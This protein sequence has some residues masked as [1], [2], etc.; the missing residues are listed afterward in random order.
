MNPFQPTLLGGSNAFVAKINPS[1][2]A[3]V[4][5][6]YLGGYEYDIG[7]GI[8]VDGSGDAYVAGFTCST[9]FPTKNA[10]QPIFRGSARNCGY[11]A[12]VTK[13]NPSGSALVYS[14]YLGGTGW[15]EGLGI[16]VDSSGSAYVTGFA[17][18]TDFPT[19]NP[20]QPTRLGAFNAF[21]TEFDP[22][23]SA[24]VYSTYLGGSGSDHGQGIAVD[25]SG[26]AYVV[27]STTS[28]DFPTVNPFQPALDGGWDAFVTKINPSGSAL[29]YSTYLGGSGEEEGLGIA[30]D[31][32]GNAS[33]TGWTTSTDFPTRNALQSAYGGAS[34]AFITT[35]DPSGSAL[36]YSSYLGGYNFD[37][38]N[39]IALDNAG[40]VYL[41][42]QTASSDFPT[43]FQLQPAISGYSDAFVTKIALNAIGTTLHLSNTEWTFGPNVVGSPSGTGTIY[44]T[45]TGDTAAHFPAAPLLYFYG[46][47]IQTT[48]GPSLAPAT[49]CNIQF[50]YT[51]YV[52]GPAETTLTLLS[53]AVNSPNVIQIHADGTGVHLSAPSW[54]F[55]PRAVGTT[56]PPGTIYLT[57]EGPA[58][59]DLLSTVS[60]TGPDFSDFALTNNCSAAVA[61]YT[62]CN[63]SFTWTP[64]AAGGRVAQINITSPQ[65]QNGLVVIP[66]TAHANQ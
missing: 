34:D 31:G 66:L 35:F 28:T 32:S 40:N 51:P 43:V 60:L 63:L 15:D 56:S 14:T 64:K 52:L 12:F 8:A 27:G 36:V 1:G 20:L 41:T 4:Y 24:L 59:M 22:A 13:F 45:N 62:T 33:V 46:L 61:P 6:T 47:Q 18:S 55:A 50:R 19:M 39:G 42:G 65:V 58:P 11:N 57:N 7:S 3:L 17:N 2:S 29:V 30:V 16:A 49:T 54:S 10:F 9:N 23:G 53:N 48:C 21:V 38:G 37:E 25:S 5:S 26:A 44:V